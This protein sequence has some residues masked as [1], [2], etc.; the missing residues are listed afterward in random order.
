V[1]DI[2]F[3]KGH[4]TENDFVVLPDESATLDLTPPRVRAVCDRASGLG[5]DGV[6]R[7]VPTATVDEV[8]DQASA[9]AWFMD[10]RNADGSLPQM[11]GNGVRVF[12]RY[13]LEAGLVDG[14]VV[15]VATRGGVREINVLDGRFAVDMGEATALAGEEVPLVTVGTRTWP[16][17]GV[18]VPNPHAVVFVDDLSDTGSLRDAPRVSPRTVY[19][20]GVNVEFVAALAADR[21]AMRVFER[22]VGETRSCGTG[23]C[24]A[25]WAWR[26]EQPLLAEAPES[27]TVQVPG[28]VLAVRERPDGHLVLS[29]P[30]VIV[31]RGSIDRGWWDSQ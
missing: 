30:A 26:R 23:A 24:A 27:V 6:L 8:A 13:L 3:L 17:V 21:L 19:P 10:H 22:G 4:G 7:V 14:P 25:A 15:P 28:G 29:G 5:A 11:C 31:A 18:H 9:A 2:A 12:V 1:D 16:A 20:D